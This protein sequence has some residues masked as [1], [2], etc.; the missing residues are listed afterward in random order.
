M[1]VIFIDEIG[2]SY[3]NHLK[4]NKIKTFYIIFLNTN[5]EHST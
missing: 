4:T 2:M 3:M 1:W 5:N